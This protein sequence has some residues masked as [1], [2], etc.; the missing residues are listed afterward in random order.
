MAELENRCCAP[1]VQET[2]CE[3]AEKASC[4]GEHH[5]DG[6][7][8]AAGAAQ[9]STT[10]AE[11]VCETVRDKYAAAATAAVSGGS[12]CFPADETVVFSASPLCREW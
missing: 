3:P 7:G 5:A 12:C 6:C 9:I 1:A 4:C 11:Q 2:C 10:A 8:C